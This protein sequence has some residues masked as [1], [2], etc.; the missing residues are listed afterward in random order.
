[1]YRTS[2]EYR[3]QFIL[4]L[5]SIPN[6]STGKNLLPCLPWPSDGRRGPTSEIRP[7]APCAY[8]CVFMYAQK[9]ALVWKP[10]L[11]TSVW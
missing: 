8:A 6:G 9:Y 5:K 1:M 3:E 2:K 7:L 11:G 10:S 4:D